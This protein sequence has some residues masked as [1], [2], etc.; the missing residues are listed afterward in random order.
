MPNRSLGFEG[1]AGANGIAPNKSI[2]R[3][4]KKRA[5]T[6]AHPYK[7]VSRDYILTERGFSV[8][9]GGDGRTES[10]ERL[11]SMSDPI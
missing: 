1:L 5:E 11:C 4:K 2:S 6:T 9:S 7:S 3:Q 10:S 8:V